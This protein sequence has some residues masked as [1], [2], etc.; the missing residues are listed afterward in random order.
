MSAVR[1][2]ALVERLFVVSLQQAIGDLAPEQLEVFE[3]WFDPADRRPR[4]HIAPV[5]GAV[6]HLRKTPTL[7]KRIMNQAG[8]YASRWSYS[9]LTQVERKVL[10]SRLTFGR[11][12]MV[13]RLLRAG[14]RSVHRDGRLET[15]RMESKLVVTV[16]ISLFFRA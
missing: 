8:F 1:N 2:G 12:H 3:K 5:I 14:L 4:F 15:E 10:Q 7:Y 11:E 16:S 13:R 6:G 9:E